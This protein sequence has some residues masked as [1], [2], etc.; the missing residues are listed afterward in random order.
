VRR[1]LRLRTPDLGKRLKGRL[2]AVQRAVAAGDYV[3]AP[4]STLRAADV[5]LQ[6]AEYSYRMELLGDGA[7]AAEDPLV[8]LLDV[9][10][11][12]RLRLEAD[13]R[14]LNRL[15]QDLRKRAHLRY[16]DRIVVSLAGEGLDEFVAVF[17]PWLMEQVLA[18]A[19]TSEP[20]E[21]AIAAGSTTL[22]SGPVH[23]AIRLGGA[24]S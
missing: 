21:H 1:V 15:I 7:A 24:R 3:I 18:V 12:E 19:I 11:D 22:T 16:S 13:A 20:L 2:P 8:V 6:P 17:G 9:E 14:D 23:A 5:V 10:R 4:D